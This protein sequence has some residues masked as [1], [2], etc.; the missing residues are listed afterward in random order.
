MTGSA[1]WSVFGIRTTLLESPH[2]PSECRR[3]I[4]EAID[5]R[6]DWRGRRPVIGSIGPR[7]AIL[8]LRRRAAVP[9][10]FTT[11]TAV[12]FAESPPGTRLACRS[13]PT[14][15]RLVV[16]CVLGGIA[17]FLLAI[18]TRGLGLVA[19]VLLGVFALGSIVSWHFAREDH[20]TL[21]RFVAKC[22][23]AKV[24]DDAIR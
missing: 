22:A 15:H 13:R 14:V 5:G 2:S 20:R 18:D 21:A 16:L 6:W 8:Y 24:L 17:V 4:A 12:T 11:I 7:K 9:S 23:Q 10:S 3:R 19:V 1:L